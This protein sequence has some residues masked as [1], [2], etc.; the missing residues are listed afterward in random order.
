VTSDDVGGQRYA[1]TAFAQG[2]PILVTLPLVLTILDMS[3]AERSRT[4]LQG[5]TT[6]WSFS[7][8]F[9]VW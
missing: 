6:T 3:R 7:G 5:L 2:A 1:P 8:Y 9:E 4:A